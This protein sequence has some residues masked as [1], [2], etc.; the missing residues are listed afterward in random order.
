M[1]K[2]HFVQREWNAGSDLFVDHLPSVPRTIVVE[3]L[4]AVLR[5]VLGSLAESAFGRIRVRCD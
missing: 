2:G 1:F 5:D 4:L 3:D